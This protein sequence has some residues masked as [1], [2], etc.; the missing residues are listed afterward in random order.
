MDQQKIVQYAQKKASL[1]F[2][3]DVKSLFEAKLHVFLSGKFFEPV[4]L[5]ICMMSLILHF[6][7]NKT[8]IILCILFGCSFWFLILTT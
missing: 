8:K 1:T 7:Q 3:K 2:N 6:S 4:G 5:H